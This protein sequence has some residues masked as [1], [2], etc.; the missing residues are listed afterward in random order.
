[1]TTSQIDLNRV[2][3]Y[4]AIIIA[5]LICSGFGYQLSIKP[6]GLE[7]KP[8]AGQAVEARDADN[9]KILAPAS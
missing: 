1:M 6:T 8:V 9:K 3:L 4:V 2:L 7:F 5:L